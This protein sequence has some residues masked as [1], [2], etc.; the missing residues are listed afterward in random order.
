MTKI[1]SKEVIKR[2]EIIFARFGYPRSVTADNG[3]QFVS[4]EFRAYLDTNGIKLT[5]TIPYWPQQNGEVE[6]QNRSILKTL[7]ISQNMKHDWRAELQKYLLAYRTS[8]HSVTGVSPAKLMFGRE[9]RDKLPCIHKAS[10]WVDE[11][12]RDRDAEK[13]EKG[14]K[15]GDERRGARHSQIEVGDKVLAKRPNKENQL[16]STDTEN[17]STK[18]GSCASTPRRLDDQRLEQEQRFFL[19]KQT[20]QPLNRKVFN[21]HQSDQQTNSTWKGQ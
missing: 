21:W 14:R 13:K 11:E 18:C 5:S 15:Y 3:K 7:V 16:Q 8:P 17:I 9:L 6:R 12:M 20:R 4:G 1:D 19:F 10:E 2:M